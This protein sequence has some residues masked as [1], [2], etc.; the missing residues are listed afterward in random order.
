M[1]N[2]IILLALCMSAF[3]FG[4]D[5]GQWSF[6]VGSNFTSSNDVTAN[7]GYFV[8]DGLMVSLEFNMTTNSGAEDANGD[9]I[10]DGT[11][12]WGIGARYYIGENGLWAGINMNNASWAHVCDEDCDHDAVAQ[13]D[14][15]GMD[16]Q[17]AVGCSK[18]LG[19][20]DKLWFEPW[21]AL[22]M[23]AA[24]EDWEGDMVETDQV[25]FGMGMGF[26]L[27]F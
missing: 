26:R 12:D 16:F 2:F 20:D 5:Q 15:T 10:E 18:A 7:A 21:M 14:E 17:L 25:T 4:Q 13:D 6:G 22:G 27:T 8:M 3:T 9:A 24:S 19:F 11:T 1:R 23:P